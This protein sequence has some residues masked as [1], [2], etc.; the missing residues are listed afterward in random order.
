MSGLLILAVLI[1]TACDGS[2]SYLLEAESL[3]E[4]DP[5]AADSILISNPEPQSLSNRAWYAVLKTQADY[6]QY[7]P[8]TSDS[9]ILSAT[10][11]YNLYRKNYRSAMAWYTRGCVY[12][13]LNDDVSAISAF[14]KAMDLFPDTLVRYYALT[15][16]CLAKCYINKS[17][18]DESL[19][20]FN[21]CRNNAI[22]LT[23]S[24]LL[25][26]VDFQ[27]A[28]IRLYKNQYD[29]LDK[30]FLRL[31]QDKNLSGFYRRECFVE[32]AKYHICHTCQY[33]SAS[34][35]LDRYIHY[36]P[37]SSLKGVYYNLKG[38][39]DYKKE[40]YDEAFSL[41]LRSIENDC[42]IY[43][44]TSSY[45]RISE[46]SL[47]QGDSRKAFEYGRLYT[48]GIDSIRVLKSANEV[49]MIRIKDNAERELFK[50]KEFRIRTIIIC[51]AII[52]TALLLLYGLYIRHLNSIKQR[53]IRF[54]DNVWTTINSPI[55]E[56]STDSEL[57]L[58]GKTKYLNSPSHYI[59]LGEKGEKDVY[60]KDS[61]AAILHDIN[62]AFS[63]IIV[64]IIS[65]DSSINNRDIQVCL[66]CYLGVD[67]HSICEILNITGDNYRKI[68]SRMKD[69]LADSYH[70]YFR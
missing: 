21:R 30:V 22:R 24:T 32:L 50:R 59:L 40:N 17:M 7:L 12:S 19:S 39:I 63:D 25:S 6:K 61:K 16:S 5:A 60:N 57:L 69:K 27:I 37:T 67:I 3:L 13:D 54:S 31:S 20:L 4:T 10:N 1:V 23:D 34:F 45:K 14:I 11:Y 2:R 9:L 55:K 47:L 53:Y 51:I 29:S 68:K 65:S 64:R 15:E 28:I 49:A 46:I 36:V 38:E 8:I 33:D 66:L 48:Q 35:Y 18:Y 62:I 70:L 58:Y 43:T 42:D 26:Y 44:L 52:L 41:Y 56:N